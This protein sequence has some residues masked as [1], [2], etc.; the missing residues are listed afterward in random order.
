VS[1]QAKHLTAKLFDEEKETDA[2]LSI[3]MPG[4]VKLFN[5]I[6]LFERGLLKLAN[7]KLSGGEASLVF[8]ILANTDANNEWWC[9]CP[10]LWATCGIRVDNQ[11]KYIR[12]LEAK[13]VLEKAY[14]IGQKQVYFLNPVLCWKTSAEQY[15]K[16]AELRYYDG[17]LSWTNE[18]KNHETGELISS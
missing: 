10:L 5:W 13:G 15:P 6:R 9:D 8:F 14:K 12:K 2:Q 17:K 1:K 7:L 16:S 4:R 3:K 11:S 18:I